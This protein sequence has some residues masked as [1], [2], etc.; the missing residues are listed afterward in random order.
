MC[1][2]VS[3]ACV[4]VSMFLTADVGE[5]LV[6]TRC[7]LLAVLKVYLSSFF[8]KTGSGHSSIIS[9]PLLPPPPPPP[10]YSKFCITSVGTFFSTKLW[11]GQNFLVLTTPN[12]CQGNR[13]LLNR[14]G[15]GLKRCY[16]LL[17]LL[18]WAL[19]MQCVMQLLSFLPTL[20]HLEPLLPFFAIFQ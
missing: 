3:C 14:A 4:C 6:H 5:D 20:R 15:S 11:R 13:W 19:A 8:F 1:A 17:C 12:E 7:Q 10:S 9:I 2:C 16:C 18:V